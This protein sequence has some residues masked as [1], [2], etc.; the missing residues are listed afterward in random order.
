MD[1]Y[2]EDLKNEFVN[3]FCATRGGNFTSKEIEAGFIA[4]F[5]NESAPKR[6]HAFLAWQA[7]Q[8]HAGR[9]L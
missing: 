7:G 8:R 6:Y 3:E 5:N 1:K 4:G 2:L 9:R